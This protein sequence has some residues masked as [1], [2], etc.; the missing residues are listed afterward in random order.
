MIKSSYLTNSSSLFTPHQ[1]NFDHDQAVAVEEVEEEEDCEV[2]GPQKD[3]P[4]KSAFHVENQNEEGGN[5]QT[6][7][8]DKKDQLD[9]EER[10]QHIRLVES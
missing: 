5:D 4:D 8:H 7:D 9:F 2:R 6:E 3:R 10:S 1:K